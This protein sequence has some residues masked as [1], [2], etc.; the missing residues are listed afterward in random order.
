MLTKKR[1]LLENKKNIVYSTGLSNLIN[2][3]KKKKKAQTIKNYKPSISTQQT[4]I[5]G[6]ISQS[7]LSIIYTQF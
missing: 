7:K 2:Y 1:Y 6:H 3:I 5:R 4:T